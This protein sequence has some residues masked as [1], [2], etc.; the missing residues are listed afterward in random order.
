MEPQLGWTWLSQRERRAAEEALSDLGPDDTRDELGFG[1]IHFAY[2]DRFF[3]GTS[4]QQTALRYVWFICWNY[5]ELQKRW[6]GTVFPANELAR[7]E[8]RTGYK[9]IRYYG[10]QD[11][12]GIIGGRVLRV[13]RSPVVKP[14][15]VYWSAM[16]SW[17]LIEPLANGAEPPSRGEIHMRWGDLT[18]RTPR[19]EV[20]PEPAR[21][22]FVDPPPTPHRWRIESVPLR[23][24]LEDGHD[25]AGR[26]RRAWAR[27]RDGLGRPTLL[28]RL[29]DRR[30]ACRTPSNRATAAY[31]LSI[32]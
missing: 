7:I 6:P 2:A 1:V 20:D 11:G 9:L 22:I 30:T 26:I 12:H 28:S 18:N 31:G 14:S 23:F 24:N 5:L 27:Q 21:P 19:P 15:M 16:R 3:P 17:G 4:V 25:E 29:A 13:G 8:D 32:D 10:A